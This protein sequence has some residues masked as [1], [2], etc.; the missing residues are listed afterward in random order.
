M[1]DGARARLQY[2][3]AMAFVDQQVR[4][5]NIYQFVRTRYRWRRGQRRRGYWTRPWIL[6]RRQFGLYDQLLARVY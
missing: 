2:A 3:L 6:R 1:E 4:A 5:V